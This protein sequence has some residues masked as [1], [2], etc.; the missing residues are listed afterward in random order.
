M[1]LINRKQQ[2]QNKHAAPIPS[3]SLPPDHPYFFL[4]LSRSK[5]SAISWRF[6]ASFR[7]LVAAVT[8]SLELFITSMSQTR[9]K[10]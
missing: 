2:V 6:S 10:R 8:S 7:R 3:S 5:M 4:C 9:T 1:L